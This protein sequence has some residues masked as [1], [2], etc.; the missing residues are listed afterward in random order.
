MSSRRPPQ[1]DD[2]DEWD[3]PGNGRGRRRPPPPPARSFGLPIVAGALVVGLVIG[4]IASCGGGGTTT[5]TDTVTVTAP[6]AA[7]PAGSGSVAPSGPAS[8]A[9]IALAILN[10][11]GEDGLA[12]TRAEAANALG[13]ENVT[14]GDAPARVTSD[15]VVYRQGA[16]ARAAQVADDLGLEAPTLAKAGDPILDVVADAAVIVV[17]GPSG[18]LT[19]PDPGTSTAPT[20]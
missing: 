4:F 14:T 17:L 13:Y 1:W 7:A 9:T 10:G 3:E 2:E 20:G 12:G 15:Q 18:A 11:S 8:R 16:A 6:A 19:T 5:V